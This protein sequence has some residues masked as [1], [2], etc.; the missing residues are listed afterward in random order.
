MLANVVEPLLAACVRP[1]PSLGPIKPGHYIPSNYENFSHLLA[2]TLHNPR[3]RLANS[4]RTLTP[5]SHWSTSSSSDPLHLWWLQA[6]TDHWHR[7][8]VSAR[9]PSSGSPAGP[10]WTRPQGSRPSPSRSSQPPGSL[11]AGCR[12]RCSTCHCR[13]PSCPVSGP[14]SN[15]V[16]IIQTSS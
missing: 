11:S 4:R 10:G 7:P 1:Q 15:D 3:R 16:I 9:A 14:C 8:C 2:L 6:S 13:W 5:V 12:R